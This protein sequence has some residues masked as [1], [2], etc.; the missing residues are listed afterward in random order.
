[1]THGRAALVGLLN[2]MLLAVWPA[3]WRRWSG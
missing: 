1:M 3:C 2:T